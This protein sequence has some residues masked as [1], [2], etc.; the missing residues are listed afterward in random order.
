MSEEELIDLSETQQAVEIENHDEIEE[1]SPGDV[2]A[3]TRIKALETELSNDTKKLKET[4]DLKDDI[5]NM[6]SEK[7]DEIKLLQDATKIKAEQS[8]KC[9][10]NLKIEIQHCIPCKNCEKHIVEAE[11]WNERLNDLTSQLGDLQNVVLE[12]KRLLEESQCMVAELN[13][14]LETC[15]KQERSAMESVVKLSADKTCMEQEIREKDEEILLKGDEI[16]KLSSELMEMGNEMNHVKLQLSEYSSRID[17]LQLENDS[18]SSK[19]DEAN[20]QLVCLSDLKAEVQ[21]LLGKLTEKEDLLKSM[22]IQNESDQC[23]IKVQEDFKQQ[24]SSL[25]DALRNKESVVQ[26]LEQELAKLRDTVTN[27]TANT[28]VSSTFSLSRNEELSRM[29]D[30]EDSFEDK[31]TKLRVVAVKLKKRVTELTQT[32]EGERSKNLA[33]KSELQAK[34]TSLASHAKTVQT[35]QSEVDRLQDMLEEQ[36]KNQ[37]QLSKLLEAAVQESA[38]KKFELA[39]VQED[40]ARITNEKNNIEKSMSSLESSSADTDVL[41]IEVDKLQKELKEK[42]VLIE[43]IKEEKQKLAEQIDG[44]CADAKKKS[45]LSLEMADMEKSVSK[46]TSELSS[47]RDLLKKVRQELEDGRSSFTS[48]NNQFKEVEGKLNEKER[49]CQELKDSLTSTKEEL[50]RVQKKCR[51][52]ESAIEQLGIQL[53]RQQAVTEE[54]N[55]QCSDL[56]AKQVQTKESGRLQVEKLSRQIFQLEEQ[57]SS[58]KDSHKALEDELASVRTEF[59]NYKVR[60]QSVLRQSAKQ[61]ERAPSSGTVHNV[62]ELEVEVERLRVNISTLKEN[63]QQTTSQLQASVQ[64]VNLE[65]EEKLRAMKQVQISK[66]S[67]SQAMERQHAAEER[68]LNVVEESK[69]AKLQSD[70]LVQCYKQQLEDLKATQQKKIVALTEQL[71]TL[72]A[73]ITN[74]VPT[75]ENDRSSSIVSGPSPVTDWAAQLPNATHSD[76]DLAMRLSSLHREEGEGSESVDSF[77]SRRISVTSQDRRHELVPLDKLLSSPTYPEDDARDVPRSNSSDLNVDLLQSKLSACESRAA[78]LTALLS[79]AESDAARLSQLNT[80]LKEEIRR[81]QRSEERA[82]HAHNLEYLKN[83]VVKF[84]TLQSGDERQRLVPVLNTILKLSPEEAGLVET[85]AKGASQTSSGGG[86]GSYLPLPSWTGS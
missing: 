4:N 76:P 14:Q 13:S 3:K 84:I 27:E 83:V 59:E 39:T 2:V 41:R 55:I 36:K 73:S 49:V 21:D 17:V 38:S 56:A 66:E 10:D 33:E 65:R 44:I 58:L 51:D 74:P 62:E 32:L 15:R 80:V 70:M 40:L 5:K 8:D 64:E 19:C 46:L 29:K 85:A 34:L 28:E 23:K 67:C 11:R 37:Q 86:W 82:Q 24:I 47:E 12:H 45:V 43:T 69:Q 7:E 1:P 57:C 75:G 68:L 61:E 53:E 6:V 25:Q 71:E 79:E 54:L 50:D 31:Y 20:K 63:L 9:V 30:L 35:L 72:Q 22:Q 26:D 16:S 60:A 18:L 81:Q 48:L 52:K 42:D 77:P 78:H